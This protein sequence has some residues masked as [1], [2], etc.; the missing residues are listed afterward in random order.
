MAFKTRSRSKSK[1]VTKKR[2]SGLPVR[3]R[4]CRFCVDKTKTLD[5]KDTK[6]LEAFIK[7]RARIVSR[8][9]SGNCAKHQRRIAVAVK[10]A[11]FLS[12]LPYVVYR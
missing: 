7:D 3:K 4:F 8:R 2:G 11:R 9:S 5:Y 1:S 10:R 6:T 12:L